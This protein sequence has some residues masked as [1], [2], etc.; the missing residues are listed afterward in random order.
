MVFDYEVYRSHD[1]RG[2]VVY[3]PQESPRENKICIGDRI[4]GGSI[5]LLFGISIGGIYLNTK[6]QAIRD[7]AVH[8]DSLIS[9]VKELNLALL[10]LDDSSDYDGVGDVI[11]KADPFAIGELVR[12]ISENPEARV[13]IKSKI[14]Q[15]VENA[16]K[17]QMECK[18]IPHGVLVSVITL[19]MA[20][21]DLTCAIDKIDSIRHS[22]EEDLKLKLD[23]YT[24]GEALHRF[25]E[26][27][28]ADNIWSEL[29]F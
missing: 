6:E 23:F 18:S 20:G 17:L 21:R 8:Y 5:L 4:F 19:E 15:I 28:A 9:V 1:R 16:S 10:E 27:T 13:S 11:E 3:P 2:N 14:D 29:G 12:I 7:R 25:K 24:F 22:R 26:Q